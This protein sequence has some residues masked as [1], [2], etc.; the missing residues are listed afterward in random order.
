MEPS[1]VEA[2]HRID[3]AEPDADAT[4]EI[5]HAAARRLEASHAVELGDDAVQAAL[6]LTRRFEPYRA[7]PGKAVRLLE[8][9]AQEASAR[10][11]PGRLGR[12]DVARA[13][14]RRTG[15]PLAMLSD[16]VELR[17]G[18]VRAFLEERV[19]GQ[20][21]AVAAMVDLVAVVKAGLN[22]PRQPLGTLPVRRPDRRRQDRAR[23]GA[24]RV[25]VRQPRP[26]LSAST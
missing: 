11:R 24:R 12:D 16:E 1:F 19:L 26:R 20:D 14:A 4:R 25:P 23:Q 5:L 13:F 18:E 9:T 7:L 8:E 15:M 10:E 2:F 6:E 22:D 3:L 21:E 17:T